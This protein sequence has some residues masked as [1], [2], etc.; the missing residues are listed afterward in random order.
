MKNLTHIKRFNESEE[1]LNSGTLDKSSS[2]SDVS[3]SFTIEDL[4]RAFDAGSDMKDCESEF[5]FNRRGYKP[6][7]SFDEWY[8]KHILKN[9]IRV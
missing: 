5:D 7:S 8:E 6:F 1:N 2:I 9:N 3:S 4:E